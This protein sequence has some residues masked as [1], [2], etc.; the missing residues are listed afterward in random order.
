MDQTQHKLLNIEIILVRPR[1]E[2]NELQIKLK[3]KIENVGYH[4]I[5]FLLWVVA[6]SLL[7]G[8]WISG[9]RRW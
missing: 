1:P 8:E 2:R 4:F 9:Y 3:L 6:R 7:T 5:L